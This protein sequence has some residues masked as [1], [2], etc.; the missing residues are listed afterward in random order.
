MSRT[1]SRVHYR[2]AKKE[3]EKNEKNANGLHISKDNHNKYIAVFFCL[4]MISF[5]KGLVIGYLIF[6]N[7]EE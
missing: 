1:S 3:I 6:G 5:I 4:L 7:D 2:V